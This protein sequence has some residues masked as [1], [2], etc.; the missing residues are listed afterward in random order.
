MACMRRA[1]PL[2]ADQ[3]RLVAPEDTERAAN[4][5]TFVNRSG[6]PVGY[7]DFRPEYSAWQGVQ[8]LPQQGNSTKQI[9]PGWPAAARSRL[10]PTLASGVRRLTV[11]D[12]GPYAGARFRKKSAITVTS[13]LEARQRNYRMGS[14][15]KKSE[16]TR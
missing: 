3:C 15:R 5:N 16:A 14:T 12:A 7:Q 9:R 1:P 2:K 10:C 11:G 8:R 13:S 4:V 6:R